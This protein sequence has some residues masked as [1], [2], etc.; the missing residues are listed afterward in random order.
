VARKAQSL[1]GH[2]ISYDIRVNIKLG[3]E[4]TYG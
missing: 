2:Q 1:F 4:A 3:K